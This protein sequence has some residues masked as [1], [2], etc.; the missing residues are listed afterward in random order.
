MQPPICTLRSAL[1][2]GLT[3]AH[4]LRVLPYDFR[5]RILLCALCAFLR[6]FIALALAV[7]DLLER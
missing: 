7:H 3:E 5:Q 6:P 2:P 4:E 1:A